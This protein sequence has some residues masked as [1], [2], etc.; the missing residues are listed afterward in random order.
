MWQY[1]TSSNG[2]RYSWTCSYGPRGGAYCEEE[3]VIGTV[4]G[5]GLSTYGCRE[6]L[7]EIV[8]K[9]PEVCG[10]MGQCQQE[11]DTYVRVAVSQEGACGE[12]FVI[13]TV[14]RLRQEQFKRHGPVNEAAPVG[15]TAVSLGQSGCLLTTTPWRILWSG[16]FRHGKEISRNRFLVALERV[17]SMG[18][19]IVPN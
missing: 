16:S 1:G 9:T 19:K 5:Y 13:G 12:E 17:P 14:T 10:S 3:L 2:A 18:V 6:G 15:D 4:N 7:V 8:T 11:Y